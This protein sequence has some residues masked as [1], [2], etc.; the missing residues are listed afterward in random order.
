MEKEQ[1]KRRSIND[2]I[3]KLIARGEL[4]QQELDAAKADA[5]EEFGWQESAPKK[6]TSR[7]D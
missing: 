1:P 3:A 5:L 4:S 6:K 2:T 7:S